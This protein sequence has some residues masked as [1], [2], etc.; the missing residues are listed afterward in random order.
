[1]CFC[2][3]STTDLCRVL[4]ADEGLRRRNSQRLPEE[5]Q[6][7]RRERRVVSSAECERDARCGGCA[8][9]AMTRMY[10]IEKKE[11][12]EEARTIIYTTSPALSPL[13][14]GHDLQSETAE[15]RRG[16]SGARDA[17]FTAQHRTCSH[18]SRTR[19]G[20]R[21]PT[22][23]QTSREERTVSTRSN[24]APHSAA[25]KLAPLQRTEA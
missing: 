9:G 14:A 6:Q 15:E 19:T 8:T 2:E 24:R 21:P 11:N 7:R 18:R 13:S 25:A 4:L 10:M 17:T 20:S 16:G 3:T 1:M 12:T 5:Q 23:T 22:D